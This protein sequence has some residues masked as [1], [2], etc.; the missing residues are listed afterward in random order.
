MILKILYG[1]AKIHHKSSRSRRR[2]YR[3]DLIMV[4]LNAKR[5]FG[6]VNDQAS[7]IKHGLTTRVN[8][9]RLIIHL[10]KHD[11][12]QITLILLGLLHNSSG[13]IWIIPRRRPHAFARQLLLIVFMV[14]R[15]IEFSLPLGHESLFPG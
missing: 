7:A 1:L 10:Y 3:S 9:R 2:K 13:N 6:I 15:I 8:R 14:C 5:S 11:L 4:E 12:L